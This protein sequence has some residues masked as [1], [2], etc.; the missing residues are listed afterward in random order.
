MTTLRTRRTSPRRRPQHQA[1]GAACQRLHHTAAATALLALPGA[2]SRSA[3]WTWATRSHPNIVRLLWANLT[4]PKCC[5]VMERC[6]CSLFERLHVQREDLDRRRIVEMAIHVGQAMEH[7]HG[8]QPPI[9]HRDIKSHNVLLDA[10][11]DCKICDFGLVNTREVTAGT[12]NYMAPEL[13]LSKPYNASVDVFAFAVLL[14]EMFAR[15]VPWDGYQP[16]DIKERVVKGEIPPTP[17]TMPHAC[18]GLLRKA[19]HQHASLRPKCVQILSTLKA[20]EQTL[21]LG[22]S[23]L[24]KLGC[25]RRSL[26]FDTL[27]EFASLRLNK[28]A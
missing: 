12:P 13:F 20:V 10:R 2:S 5:I 18:E 4:P 24:G 15:E 27:D 11:G 1:A 3:S 17:R 6:S 19:W 22:A 21:P 25:G 28:T 14:N 9:V 8:C 23:A 26:N 16:L 7:L